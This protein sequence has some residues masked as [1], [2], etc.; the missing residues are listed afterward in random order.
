MSLFKPKFI[1]FD[2]DDTL[3]DHKKAE[4]DGLT[5]VYRHFDL[6][7]KVS[8][9]ELI[10]VYHGIN[11]VLWDKYGHGEIDKTTLIRRRFE[12]T[13][14]ALGLESRH[15]KEIGEFYMSRYQLHWMWKEEAEPAYNKISA[16]FEV[17]ILTNGFAAT[18]RK[19]IE[20]FGFASSARE[21]VISEEHGALKPQPEIFV[22]STELAGVSPDEILYVGDSLVS[23]VIGG[24]N[25]G[26]NTAW[27][28]SSPDPEGK[29]RAD[30]IFD[31]FEALLDALG[32]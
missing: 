21:I 25:A 6:F 27:F 7:S 30:F 4:K 13:L 2:L 8:A 12:D 18:Q 1:Y 23:D 29:E 26:W 20:Q 5:D 9:A 24:S 22:K 32:L 3:L 15:F 10:E 19:K 28:T 31:N 14:K 17:G 16:H 11:R